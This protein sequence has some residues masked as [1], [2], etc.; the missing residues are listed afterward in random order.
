MAGAASKRREAG[1]LAKYA[2]YFFN[3]IIYPLA[4]FEK[5]PILSLLR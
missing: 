4:N 5:P 3:F 2:N 1:Y